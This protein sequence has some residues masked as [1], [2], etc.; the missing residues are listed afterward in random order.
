MEVS[1][2]RGGSREARA[3]KHHKEGP[4]YDGSDC[5]EEQ[6]GDCDV[7]LE[8][9]FDNF[10]QNRDHRFDVPVQ[11]DEPDKRSDDEKHLAHERGQTE[12]GAAAFE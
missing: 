7:D 2:R 11:R 10:S 5:R 4:T 3:R 12:E 8:L 9:L 6:G 1:R